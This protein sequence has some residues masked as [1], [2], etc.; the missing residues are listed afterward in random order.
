MNS[1]LVVLIMS[2]LLSACRQD[3]N[4]DIETPQFPLTPDPD[5]FIDYFN[6]APAVPKSGVSVGGIDNRDDFPEAYYNTIDP[7]KTRASFNDWRI[8]NGFLNEDHTA[9]DCDPINC[10]SAHVKFRDTK[11]LGY[12][13][14]MF[15]RRDL[16]TGNVAVYVENFQVD[17]VP[18]VPYGPLNL[19]A[20]IE[21]DR[22]WNFGFNAI[23]FSAYPNTSAG[24]R[25]FVK[26]YNFAGDGKRATLASGTQ[27][28]DVDLDGRGLKPVPTPCI[29]CHGGRGRTLVYR[30]TD[31]TKK[32]APTI[33]G[34]IPGDVQANMQLLEFNT[35]QFSTEP[36]F[37]REDNAEGI[38][39]INEA[40]LSTF[41][42]HDGVDK[43]AGDWDPTFAMEI[44]RGRYGNNPSGVNSA[45]DGSFVPNDWNANDAALY[46]SQIGPNCIVCHALRG[47]GLNDSQTFST[48]RQFLDYG[49]RIDH[50]LFDQSLMPLGLLNYSSFWENASKDPGAIAAALGH[51]ERL[52]A[53]QR[54]MRPGLPV[55]VIAAPPIAAGIDTS[56]SPAVVY[57]VAVSGN[58]SAYANVFRWSVEPS[59]SAS[60]SSTS[61]D[62]NAI[63]EGDAILQVTQAGVYTISLEVEGS[64]VDATD[65]AS[66]TIDVR[67]VGA[68]DAPLPADQINYYGPGGIDELISSASLGCKGCHAGDG[69]YD[70]IPLYYEPCRSDVINGY[71]FVY[72]SVL[73]RVNFAAPLNSMF[74]RKPTMGATDPKNR[75]GSTIDDYHTGG[76]RLVTDKDYSTV[77]SWILNGAPQG[78][79]PQSAINATAPGCL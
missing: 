68:S 47:S 6:K 11:D 55:A 75:D 26:F 62:G 57:D 50:L 40:V 43:R 64:V 51:P 21:N 14:N 18:G 78:D 29:L 13:R 27:A 4:A 63:F 24:A 30:D 10:V 59:A 15:M 79:Q 56:S 54:A 76:Y 58:D 33:T 41:V 23:E 48:Y 8:Q 19:Q 7:L 49:D 32:L 1:L 45:F 37:T 77:L 17:R 69:G 60:I 12:G 46:R 39:L 73:A 20:L 38:R 2:V 9:A 31:G 70:G 44:A 53:N 65:S 36:G 71:D 72:R 25:Q 16:T 42:A 67:D 28:H 34:G 61:V 66:F 52:D 5:S 35:L 3:D 74:L 22:S